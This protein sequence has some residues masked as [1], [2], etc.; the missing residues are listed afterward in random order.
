MFGINLFHTLCNVNPHYC[1]MYYSDQNNI[2]SEAVGFLTCPASE[3]REPADFSNFFCCIFWTKFYVHDG[4]H[5]LFS[6][7]EN[8]STPLHSL[9]LVLLP[10]R[11]TR[12]TFYLFT[13][14]KLYKRYWIILM[15]SVLIEMYSICFY[16]YCIYAL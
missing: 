9:Y 16:I 2:E 10:F 1:Y 11:G 3:N 12:K 14:G 5:L 15:H 8:F 7:L 6:I 13:S 4:L